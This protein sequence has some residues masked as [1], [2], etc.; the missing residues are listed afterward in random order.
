MKTRLAAAAVLAFAS[1]SGL[2]LAQSAG[3]PGPVGE[4][5]MTSAIGILDA[6]SPE[7]ATIALDNGN[8]FHVPEDTDFTTLQP[9]E[10]VQVDYHMEGEERLA[11]QVSPVGSIGSTDHSPD[12]SDNGK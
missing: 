6:V 3:S 1:G 7:D 2:A 4:G 10:R 8:I 12:S 5:E 9:G 11:T